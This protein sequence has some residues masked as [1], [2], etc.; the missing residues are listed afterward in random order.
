MHNYNFSLMELKLGSMQ[1][2]SG[3]ETMYTCCCCLENVHC[4][5]KIASLTPGTHLDGHKSSENWFHWTAER[6]FTK[7]ILSEGNRDKPKSKK[8]PL[9]SAHC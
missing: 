4:K 8:R 2:P 1:K 9:C 6:L 3:T 5:E 7:N